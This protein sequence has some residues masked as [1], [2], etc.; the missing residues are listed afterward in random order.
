MKRTKFLLALVSLLPLLLALTTATS[1]AAIIPIGG[2]R[3]S[4]TGSAAGS[5]TDTST[6]SSGCY[7]ESTVKSTVSYEA[8]SNAAC[9]VNGND[10]STNCYVYSDES[11]VTEYRQ[12]DCNTITSVEGYNNG[13]SAGKNQCGSGKD[14]V[15][16]TIDFGCYGESCQTATPDAYCK[17]NHSSVLDLVFALI[18]FLTDGAGLIIVLG[19]IIAGIQFTLSRGDPQLRAK[20]IGRIANVVI[21]LFLFIFAY[22]LLNYVIP[23]GFFLS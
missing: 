16:T 6:V 20:A 3:G 12:A 10:P 8:E 1:F 7:I 2:G 11:G 22:A 4:S 19:F 21:A 23:N 17:G 13:D 15:S 9:E 14:A 18:R 5:S